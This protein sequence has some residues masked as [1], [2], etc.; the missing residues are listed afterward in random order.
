MTSLLILAAYLSWGGWREN[1]TVP[2]SW[3]F[4]CPIDIP[5]R[6][7]PDGQRISYSQLA[8][9]IVENTLAE[10]PLNSFRVQLDERGQLRWSS[11]KDG[12]TTVVRKEP[13]T[14]WWQRFSAGFMR[15]LPIR[16]QL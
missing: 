1:P 16:G 15:L 10:F 5:R 11:T 14:S 2:R 9:R 6:S 3:R 7:E 12:E 13:G 4:P 8:I